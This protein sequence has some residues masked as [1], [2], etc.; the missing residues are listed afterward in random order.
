MPQIVMTDLG[1]M[2]PYEFNPRDNERAIESTA[3]SIRTFGFLVPIVLDG[4]G[5]IVAGHEV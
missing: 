3:N 2:R 4:Q 1:D 5:S